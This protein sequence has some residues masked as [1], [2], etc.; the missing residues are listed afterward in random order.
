MVFKIHTKKCE[1]TNFSYYY[2]YLL[3]KGKACIVLRTIAI[4]TIDEN[5]STHCLNRLTFLA[6]EQ[7]GVL[8]FETIELF[9][10]ELFL[11]SCVEESSITLSVEIVLKTV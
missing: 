8:N 1:C 6:Q 11:L 9:V 2:F 10:V 5:N 4:S 7:E 3:T